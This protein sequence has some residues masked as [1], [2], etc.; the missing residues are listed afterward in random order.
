[1]K[2]YY[3]YILQCNDDSYYTGITSKVTGSPVRIPEDPKAEILDILG[4]SYNLVK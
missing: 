3:V 2:I 4:G 1:M